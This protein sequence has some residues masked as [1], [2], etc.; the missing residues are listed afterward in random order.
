MPQWRQFPVLAPVGLALS[1]LAREMRL[2]NVRLGQIR[3][4]G[5]GKNAVGSSL[6]PGS[7]CLYA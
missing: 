7:L 4:V 1:S 2:K 5:V 3:F 6:D